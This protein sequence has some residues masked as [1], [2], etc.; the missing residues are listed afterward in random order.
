MVLPTKIVFDKFKP[1]IWF[2]AFYFVMD[3]VKAETQRKIITYFYRENITKRKLYTMKHFEKENA[4]WRTVY[5]LL[6]NNRIESRSIT[7]EAL[8]LALQLGPAI[9]WF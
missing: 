4:N 2:L 9:L 6:P 8:P 7:R 5:R 1:F 3:G